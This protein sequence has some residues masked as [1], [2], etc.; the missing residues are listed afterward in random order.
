MCSNRDRSVDD[1]VCRR[2][3][4]ELSR[5]SGLTIVKSDDA[6][7]RGPQEASQPHLSTAVPPRLGY[8]PRRH[9]ER[10]VMLKCP[11]QDRDDPSV[12]ALETDEGAGVEDHDRH[13]PS[14]WSAAARSAAVSGPPVSA[15]I[16][17]SSDARSSS[18]ACSSRAR[19]T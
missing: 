3:T 8:D 13:R 17:S 19:A 1:I 9:Q 18:F 12:V 14:A 4:A 11:D 16:S 15:S 6:T 5:R 10:I 2:S 7:Q